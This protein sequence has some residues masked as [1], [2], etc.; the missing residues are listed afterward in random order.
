MIDTLSFSDFRDLLATQL[1]QPLPGQ[2]AQ[3]QMAPLARRQPEMASVDARSCREAAV[4]ALFYPC[5]KGR[6]KLLLTVRPE[7]MNKHAGQ[8]AFPGGRR[9]H[10]EELEQTA[11]RETEEEVFIPTS[12]VDVLGKLT[13]LYIPPSNFCVYPYV[14][15]IDYRPD[16]KRTSDEVAAMFGVRAHELILPEKREVVS[17]ELAGAE[18]QI[19]YFAFEGY[20]IWG[21]TA[22]MMSELAAVLNPTLI[23]LPPLV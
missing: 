17:R 20:E 13:P 12:H 5:S 16:M 11:L 21:A 7:I 23:E 22:M 3:F 2:Q 19:P 8:V 14:G 10:G 4:L 18:R 9:E 15:V 1:S 6:P